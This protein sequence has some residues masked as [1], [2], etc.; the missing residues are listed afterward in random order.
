MSSQEIKE[1][2]ENLRG[3]DQP[4]MKWTSAKKLYRFIVKNWDFPGTL[5]D[6]KAILAEM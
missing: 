5:E 6:A 4:G 3:N 2:A 1:W